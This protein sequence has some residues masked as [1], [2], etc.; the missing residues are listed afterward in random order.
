MHSAISREITNGYTKQKQV[1]DIRKSLIWE[2][3]CNNK[4]KWLI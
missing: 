1:K 2:I 4:N 3:K